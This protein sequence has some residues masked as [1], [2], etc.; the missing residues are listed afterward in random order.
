MANGNFRRTL[1]CAAVAAALGVLCTPAGA[2]PYRG[3]FDPTDFN[4]EYIIDVNPVCL[5]NGWH[6]NNPGLCAATLTSAFANVIASPDATDPVPYTG[7][8]TFAGPP[9]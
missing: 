4:G 5:T 8:L 2:A 9:P 1:V 7:T 3:T 6:A